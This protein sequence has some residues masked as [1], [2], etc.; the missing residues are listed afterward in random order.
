M[1]PEPDQITW[2]AA[3]DG[4]KAV[5]F[6]NA[7][8]DDAVNLELVERFDNDN[9]PDRQQTPD[10]P[11]R[12]QDAGSGSKGANAPE[13]LAHGR[14]GVEHTDRH[15]L[16]KMRFTDRLVDRLAGEAERQRFDRLVL[17]ADHKSLGEARERLTDRLA[18]RIITEEAKDVVN[19]PASKLEAR[20]QT[21]L[22]DLPRPPAR[23][24]LGL[25]G[26]QRGD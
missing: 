6:R 3:F 2:I 15:A 9:P 12:F 19:E 26:P 14:S 7:G 17:I 21:L 25:S 4:G 20:V 13:G 18:R 16:E 10:R 1:R 22:Q 8:F 11:G 24:H 23:S 5:V